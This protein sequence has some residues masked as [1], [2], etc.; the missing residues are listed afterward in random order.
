MFPTYLIVF[1]TELPDTAQSA[2]SYYSQFE[3]FE[4]EEDEEEEDGRDGDKG[5]IESN[6]L[7]KE[8]TTVAAPKATHNNNMDSVKAD[9]SVGSNGVARGTHDRREDEKGEDQYEIAEEIEGS[10]SDTSTIEDSSN[11]SSG[12][13]SSRGNSDSTG[14]ESNLIKSFHVALESAENTGEWIIIPK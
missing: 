9:R 7:K 3:D 10:V 13:T 12:S 1:D 14:S 4:D 5:E 2:E 8:N 6:K 11:N